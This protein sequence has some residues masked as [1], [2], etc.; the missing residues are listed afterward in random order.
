MFEDGPNL[1][2]RYTRE[3]LHELRNRCSVFEVL[4]QSGNRH[5]GAG[6]HPSTADSLGISFYGRAR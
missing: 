1:F 2:K 4:E 3:P 6:E 5:A